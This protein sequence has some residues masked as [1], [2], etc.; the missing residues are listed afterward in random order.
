LYQRRLVYNIK[1]VHDFAPGGLVTVSAFMAIFVNAPNRVPVFELLATGPQTISTAGLVV[2]FAMGAGATLAIVYMLGGWAALQGSWWPTEPPPAVGLAAHAG[3]AVL[4]GGLVALGAPSIWSGV[5]LAAVLVGV[6]A[7]VTEKVVFRSFREQGA[8]L[9]TL[10]IAALGVSLILRFGTQAIYGG[11]SRNYNVPRTAEL[12]GETQYLT[13]AKFV[14]VYFAGP[15][16]VFH[17][18]DTGTAPNSTIA[19]VG[20]GWPVLLVVVERV[21]TQHL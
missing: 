12:F 5:L 7:P 16:A 9:A 17:I 13:A 4:V 3:L 21:C 11:A 6:I 20:Y 14:D 18:M 1:K 19:T 8:S 15:G 10:L 2:L